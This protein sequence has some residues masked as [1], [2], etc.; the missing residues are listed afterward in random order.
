MSARRRI[1]ISDYAVGNPPEVLITYGLG[2]CLG[3]LL[4]DG[5]RRLGGMAH[6]LLPAPRP[7]LA[8]SRP[9]KFVTSAIEQMLAELLERGARREQL[10]AKIFGGATMFEGLGSESEGIGVRNA[11]TARQTLA[12]LGIPLLSADVGG[13]YGRTVEFELASGIVLVR[14][15]RG[16]D[17]M[18]RFDPPV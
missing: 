8:E 13:Q 7:G 5:H 18:T 17:T 4:Y 3:I 14:S 6:T 10:A 15:V 11:R 9:G 2:S 1:G 12:G 16:G